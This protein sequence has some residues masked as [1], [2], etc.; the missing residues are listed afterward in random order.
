VLR[1]LIPALLFCVG[2]VGVGSAG[3]KLIEGTS[4]PDRL[5]GTAR[6]DQLYGRAGND[7]IDGRGASDVID[8]GPGRDRLSGSGGADRLV[9]NGDVWADSVSCGSARDVVTADPTDH[10]AAN[11]EVVSRQVSRDRDQSAEA[12]HETQ[13]EPDSAAYGSTIVTVFQS[14]RFID[15]G[16]A[17]I[18]FA[19]SRN[20]GLT[21]RSGDLPKLSI[22]SKP[23]GPY[24]AV[25]DPVVA[26]DRI[27][28]WWLAVSL[29]STFG[30]NA[31]AV[32]RSRD[33]VTWN[34]PV[35]AARS[36]VDEYDKEWATCDNWASSRFSG[37]CYVAYMNFTHATIE[38][39]RS[40][41]GGRTWSAATSIEAS[42]PRNV[43]NG[44]QIAVRPNGDVVLVFSAFGGLASTNELASTLSTDG[45]ATFGPPVHVGA[46][47]V[48]EP[49]WMRAPPFASVDVDSAGTIYAVWT[50]CSFS[51][52]CAADIVLARS[53]DGRTWTGPERIPLSAP[54]TP[55][56]HFVPA[57]AVQPGTGGARARLALLY[58]SLKQLTNCDPIYGCLVVDVKL[59]QSPDGGA[60]WTRP[61]RLNAV[62]MPPFWMAN[63]TLGYMLGDYVSVSWLAGRPVPVFSLASEP[64]TSGRLRQAVFATPRLG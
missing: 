17:S 41:D 32:S 20:R 61:Q 53:R 25:S 44:V 6:P 18:G 39:R 8:G 46:L 54:N 9:T 43:V 16:A 64:A 52:Q 56:D 55:V 47:V 49:T 60:T 21:W 34:A 7:Q 45:G 35:D 14:G 57:L 29:G 2:L 3:A 19:T 36:T 23:A 1:R 40:T 12:Q 33:G 63:T 28:R 22:S 62:S 38:L 58:H 37:T 31:I 5:N 15:G 13:V 30:L 42:R 51:E 59:A 4:G 27:H 48:S 11:C 26:Y 24:F 50:D 10:V